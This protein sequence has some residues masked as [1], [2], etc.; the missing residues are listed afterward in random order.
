MRQIRIVCGLA[1][2]LCAL[3]IT[4]IPASAADFEATRVGAPI[5]E[6]NPA[7]THS[8]G[9]GLEFEFGAFR[10]QCA[11]AQGKGTVRGEELQGL[12]TFITFRG[13]VTLLKAGTHTVTVRTS[14]NGGASVAFVYRPNRVVEVGTEVAEAGSEVEI[15]GGSST[16]SVHQKICTIN[17]PTQIVTTT[18]KPPPGEF[19][20]ASYENESATNSYTATHL[21]KFPFSI[22]EGKQTKINIS[23]NLKHMEFQ[24]EGGQCEEFEKTEFERG[25]FFG[26]ITEEVVGGNL[27]FNP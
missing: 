16:V 4:A 2:T 14:F 13:C 24:Y 23:N 11:K 18:T 26:T 15:S 7:Q 9:T 6:G 22:N 25:K 20:A 27:Q 19:S 17:W 21:Q 8:A 5:S 3:A 12:A 1:L 10:I